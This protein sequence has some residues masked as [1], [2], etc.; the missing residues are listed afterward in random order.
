MRRTRERPYVTDWIPLQIQG[1]F[2]RALTVVPDDRG[3]FAELW[4]RSSGVPGGEGFVQI[5]LARSRRGVLRGMHFHLRQADLWAVVEGRIHAALVDLRSTHDRA[6]VRGSPA[7]VHLGPGDQLYIPALVAHG[8]IV[9][10]AA[11]V[12][13]FVSREYDAQDEHGFAWDD[14]LAAIPWPRLKE[15]ILSARD[16]DAPGLAAAMRRARQQSADR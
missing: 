12:L 8:Y 1:V 10:K 5:N 13:Y 3:S 4:R 6:H 14:P 9:T 2:R 15:K 7:I 16:R 11:T